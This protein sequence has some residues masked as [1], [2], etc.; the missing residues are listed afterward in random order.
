[1][2]ASDYQPLTVSP[3]KLAPTTLPAKPLNFSH[4]THRYVI[5]DT[6][7]EVFGCA[8]SK[9]S[10]LLATS[11]ADGSIGVYSSMVGDQ[12]YHLKDF[13]VSY[14]ITDLCWKPFGA[15]QFIGV[16]ADGRIISWRPKLGNKYETLI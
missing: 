13:N 10:S 9:D 3:S 6:E 4:I 16:G 7:N 1:M 15:Q 14:P 5:H 12:L 2:Q 11:Y 8:F